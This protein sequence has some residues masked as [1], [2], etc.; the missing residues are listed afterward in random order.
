MTKGMAIF[1]AVAAVALLASCGLGKGG[2]TTALSSPD[3]TTPS[4]DPVISTAVFPIDAA[5]ANLLN[6]PFRATISISGK[7]NGFS[8]S[9]TGTDTWNPVGKWTFENLPALDVVNVTDVTFTVNGSTETTR[10]ATQ[11]YYNTNYL[12][13]GQVDDDG[14]YYVASFSGWPAAAKVG[15][16]GS[17]G[18]VT[19]YAD[20]TKASVTGHQQL[21]YAIEADAIDTAIFNLITVVTDAANAVVETQQDRYR[22]TPAGT[23]TFVSSRVILSERSG[24]TDVL[25][26]VT[27]IQPLAPPTPLLA[28]SQAVAYQI[29]PSHS[30]RVALGRPLN[31]SAAPAWSAT[32]GGQ[33]SYPLIAG[34]KVFV[35]TEGSSSGSSSGSQLYALDEA[36]GNIAW[37]PVG[38][39]G[40][41]FFSGH[42]YDNGK[43]FVV[44][45]DGVLRSFDAATGAAGWSIQLPG[46]YSFSAPPTAVD[47]IVY[48]D[49]AGIGGTLYAVDEANGHVLWTASVESG[50]RSSPTVSGEGVFVSYECET[51][52]FDPKTGVLLWRTFGGCTGGG[53]RTAAYGNGLL[54]VRHHPSSPRPGQ[55]F[56]SETGTPVGAFKASPFPTPIP[57][58]GAHTGFFQ[59]G[60]TLEAIDLA[61]HN[62][63]WS[64]AGDGQIVSAPIVIDNVVIIASGSG[65]VYALDSATGAPLW[66]GNAGAQIFG[67]EDL[68]TQ[69]LR[70]IGA[71]E[72]YLVVPAGKVLTAWRY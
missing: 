2:G 20:S 57:A 13:V 40:T 50:E 37:G 45:F 36:T 24:S 12:P 59:S 19:I 5:V 21:S 15:D 16:T 54:Y 8:V 17:L 26:A 35:T 42:A 29:D 70:G 52:K 62:V 64:F 44:N 56:D 34:G 10:S 46:Q 27:S 14:T 4:S 3:T 33:I 9:G 60:G 18:A 47:G 32:L 63:L 71:G 31:L 43:I 22:I 30:G 23:I 11:Q 55:T 1:A 49:G 28:L 7:I 48:V 69:H 39:P 67:T 51:Y 72:G 61:T 66:S 25:F 6:S 38:I 68:S 58:I 53:G 41:F 65:N